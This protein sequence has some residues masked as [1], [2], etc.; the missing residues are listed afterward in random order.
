MDL[1]CRSH[2]KWSIRKETFL[3]QSLQISTCT[4]HSGRQ[5]VAQQ[6]PCPQGILLDTD[7][8]LGRKVVAQRFPRR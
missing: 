5:V 8:Q 6:F 2:K 1:D 3:H 7:L 4:H